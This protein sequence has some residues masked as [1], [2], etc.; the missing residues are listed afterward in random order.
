MIN[1][2]MYYLLALFVMNLLVN[3]QYIRNLGANAYIIYKCISCFIICYHQKKP[4]FV[5]QMK[6][7]YILIFFNLIFDSCDF[8]LH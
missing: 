7:S 6:I 8:A 1:L 5:I 4:L 2:K 3:K